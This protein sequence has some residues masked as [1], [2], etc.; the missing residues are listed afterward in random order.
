MLHNI[1]IKKIDVFKGLIFGKDREHIEE[2]LI[3]KLRGTI[4]NFLDLGLKS[5]HRGLEEDASEQYLPRFITGG[6]YSL[7][8]N[9]NKELTKKVLA[10]ATEDNIIKLKDEFHE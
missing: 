1:K 6:Y 3:G 5:N 10:N 4:Y 7:F 2:E 9:S 8:E